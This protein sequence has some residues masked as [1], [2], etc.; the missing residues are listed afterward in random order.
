[1]ALTDQTIKLADGRALGYAEF[2]DPSGMPVFFFHGFPASRLE[3][4]PLDAPARAVGVRVIAPDRPGFGLSDPKRGRSFSDWPDDVIQLAVHLGIYDFAVL[5]TSGG[6]PYVVACADRIS[7][8]LTAAG[9]VSGISP[10]HN[11]AVRLTMDPDQRRMFVSVAR[12][13]WLAR[14][15]LA[16]SMQEVLADFP[17]LLK[18]MAAER[19]DVDKSVLE[20]PDIKDMLRTN[21]IETFRQGVAGAA[22]E[23]ALYP[24]S[25]RLALKKVV[26]PIQIWQGRED[27]ITPP[28]MAEE[29]ASL[30]PH[31]LTRWYPNE[32]HSLLFA[33]SEEILRQ[34][35]S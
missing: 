32:G 9:I 25:W 35:V 15:V 8:R 20:R 34:L 14:R 13:P 10:L 11:R 4:I 19:P 24:G 30:L 21:L 28:S 7:E 16:R 26:Y 17:S 23:L 1:M 2:G 5:G 27:V 6:S 18:R 29:L 33:R 12:F 22:Q 31:T 3:G